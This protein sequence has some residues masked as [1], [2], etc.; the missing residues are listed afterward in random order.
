MA[1]LVH[2]EAYICVAFVFQSPLEAIY[3]YDVNIILIESVPSIDDT[4]REE[5]FF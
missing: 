5:V 2:K 4:S 1:E 3:S